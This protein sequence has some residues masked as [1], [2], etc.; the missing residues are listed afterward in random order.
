MTLANVTRNTI[1]SSVPLYS[2]IGYQEETVV[3]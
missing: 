2:N 3:C 1:A